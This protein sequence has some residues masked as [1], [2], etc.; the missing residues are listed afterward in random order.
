MQNLFSGTAVIP[1]L[2]QQID[3]LLHDSFQANHSEVAKM[4]NSFI[5]ALDRL[6]DWEMHF[7]QGC[8][9]AYYW[10]QVPDTKTI[11]GPHAFWF[12]NVTMANVYTHLWA[13][14]I[15]CLTE[16]DRLSLL[17]PAFVLEIPAFASK[18]E[19]GYI[20]KQMVALSKQTCMGM[21][22]LMQDEMRLF[23]TCVY[24]LSTAGGSSSI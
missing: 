15:V 16:I 17:F 20:K 12:P 7:Q 1:D 24:F 5:E 6:K 21:E 23:R 13:F 3:I 11:D 18:F 14:R 9:E 19:F 2:L 4:L 10:P 22:Y 8:P